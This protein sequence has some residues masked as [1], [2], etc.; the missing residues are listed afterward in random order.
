MNSRKL[1]FL[2][3]DG[4]LLD[5]SYASND[6]NLSEIIKK[7][8]DSGKYVFGLNSNRSIEDMLPIARDFSI[9]GPLIGEM[10]FLHMT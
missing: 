3:I 8:Q 7:L 4:T 6:E 10:A 5:S 9:N 2:D 1:I